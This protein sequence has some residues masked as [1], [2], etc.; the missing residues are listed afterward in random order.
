[1]AHKL[2]IYKTRKFQYSVIAGLATM[3]GYGM[4]EL[5]NYL[6][7]KAK[8]K[9]DK[10]ASI[11]VETLKTENRQHEEILKF[12]L[13]Q[14]EAAQKHQYAMEYE[15]LR[16]TN[17]ME[18]L[19]AKK[20]KE[21]VT[22]EIGEE[23]N[24]YQLIP[25]DNLGEMVN[26]PLSDAA[27]IKYLG[28]TILQNRDIMLLYGPPGIGKS[29]EV[30]DMIAEITNGTSSR[31]VIPLQDKTTMPYKALYYDKEPSKDGW[32]EKF[33][34][35][36]DLYGIEH[37]PCSDLNWIHLIKDIKGR[38]A[39]EP[40]TNYVIVIDP[41]TYFDITGNDCY[42]FITQLVNIQESELGTGRN[43]TFELIAHAVKDPKGKILSDLGGSKALSECVKTV[44][45]LMPI[46]PQDCFLKLTFDKTRNGKEV[47][48][49]TSFILRP[50][51]TPH[52]H[53]NYDEALTTRYRET[54][55]VDGFDVEQ[56]QHKPSC[57]KRTGKLAKVSEEDAE[58][59]YQMSVVEG[60]SYADIAKGIGKKYKLFPAEV[61]RLIDDLQKQRK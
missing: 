48:R 32:C 19:E 23:D 10:D 12:E 8:D 46:G 53:H 54:G 5:V 2:P 56:T 43:I 39:L 17:R 28:D 30:V 1:M 44:V 33:R 29:H 50:E 22:D 45:S 49:G 52:R 24:E 14:K 18:V 3:A 4:R 57:P 60:Q 11:E 41:I 42:K 36:K 47:T 20:R 13:R 58:L 7:N 26:S 61:K 25:S 6:S 59:M 27:R 9:R 37:I 34:G 31:K 38:I 21:N 16:H 51:N 55:S 15:V 40:N 35:R